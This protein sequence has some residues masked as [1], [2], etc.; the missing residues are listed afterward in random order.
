MLVHEPDDGA[1]VL[2]MAA[3]RAWLADGRKIQVERAPTYHGAV[4]MTIESSAASGLIRASV[5]LPQRTK[6]AVLLVRLR[7]PE[8]SQIRSVA[9]NGR[10]WTDFDRA[11]EWVRIADPKELRYEIAASY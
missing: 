5:Q 11:K 9:V 2:G 1:L 8:G 7:H 4:S 6:P 10:N 3:P